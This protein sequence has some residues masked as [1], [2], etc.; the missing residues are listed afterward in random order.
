M[1]LAIV[2]LA[3]PFSTTVTCNINGATG[4]TMKIGQGSQ[5]TGTMT[6]SSALT[7]ATVQAALNGAGLG[8]ITVT[9]ST[10]GPYTLVV[11][12]LNAA[13]PFVLDSSTGGSGIIWT[14]TTSPNNLVATYT[15]ALSLGVSTA[16]SPLTLTSAPTSGAVTLTFSK[17]TTTPTAGSLVFNLYTYITL[18]NGG[19]LTFVEPF[20]FVTY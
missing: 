6:T 16:T 19:A 18:T 12:N 17:G 5:L 7:V 15:G 14:I 9:G 8:D 13:L 20:T 1:T 10:G 3:A 11:P 2:P 4:G